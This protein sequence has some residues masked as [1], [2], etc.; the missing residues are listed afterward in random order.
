MLSNTQ[1]LR[2][3]SR[4]SMLAVRTTYSRR[5]W[6]R[7][8]CTSRTYVAS[9]TSAGLVLLR[10]NVKDSATSRS[11][12]T[13]RLTWRSPFFD[14]SCFL[15]MKLRTPLYVFD[16]VTPAPCSSTISVEVVVTTF[17]SASRSSSSTASMKRLIVREASPRKSSLTRDRL[18][19][20]AAC[21]LRTL[22]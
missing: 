13:S 18:S 21:F 11:G 4:S 19:S 7:P 10:G 20:S 3:F 14:A 5:A 22:F 2:P 17:P 1:A 15:E 16:T 12:I 6:S 9:A 8:P